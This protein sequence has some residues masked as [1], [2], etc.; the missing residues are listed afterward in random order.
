MPLATDS[1]RFQ[2]S[3]D[4][5]SKS[6]VP[7]T[8]LI[9]VVGNSMLTWLRFRTRCLGNLGQAVPNPHLPCP[10][11]LCFQR[12]KSNLGQAVPTARRRALLLFGLAHLQ[13]AQERLL[14]NLD[15]AHALHPPL[16]LF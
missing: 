4:G 1:T 13:H 15:L 7:L 3:V 6:L 5:G 10:K 9:K 11:A 2:L 14:W 16:A 8:A 12:P